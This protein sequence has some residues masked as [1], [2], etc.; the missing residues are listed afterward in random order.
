MAAPNIL[1][2]KLMYTLRAV[3]N[4]KLNEYR[5]RNEKGTKLK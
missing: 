5:I 1:F 2:F 3:Y 4:P